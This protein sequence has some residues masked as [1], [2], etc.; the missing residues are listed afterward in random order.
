MSPSIVLSVCFS[1]SI[2]WLTLGPLYA[3]QYP[4]LCLFL[5]QIP[6]AISSMAHS[7]SPG[8]LR[9]PKSSSTRILKWQTDQPPDMIPRAP[10][11]WLTLWN[12]GELW[13]TL[14]PLKPDGPGSKPAS[15]LPGCSSPGDRTSVFSTVK[16]GH[17]NN[18]PYYTGLLQGLNEWTCTNT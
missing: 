8:H 15:P 12:W 18:S 2:P 3:I 16:W 5:K 14:R 10:L 6:E 4:P 11:C 1:S 7:L 17:N 13:P 9:I